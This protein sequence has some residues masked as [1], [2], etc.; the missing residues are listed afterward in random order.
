MA[1]DVGVLARRLL[2]GALRL[3]ESFLDLALEAL[4]AGKAYRE[5]R[6]PKHSGGVRILHE[7]CPT[8]MAV[9]EQIL[10]LLYRLYKFPKDSPLFGYVPGRSIVDNAMF[11]GQELLEDR[12][13]GE[14]KSYYKLRFIP[15]WVVRLDLKDA[16]PSVKT[17]LLRPMY[18]SLLA[19]QPRRWS[20]CKLTPELLD[21]VVSFLL[22]FT[23]YQGCIPQGAPSSGYLLNLSLKYAGVIDRIQEI[24]QRFK[25]PLRFSIYADDITI[26]S[27]KRRIS[28]RTIQQIMAA[29]EQGGWFRVNPKKTQRTR[30]KDRA[31]C[32]IGVVLTYRHQN[33]C[34]QWRQPILTLSQETLNHW[35]G[36]LHT[37]ACLLE[38]GQEPSRESNGF[39]LEQVRGYAQW[40]RQVYVANHWP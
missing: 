39:S 14:R 8:L 36:C 35:R 38:Q 7:P 13:G 23:T 1:E 6:I 40:I 29:I 33:S 31:H 28:D 11:H 25:Q 37:A 26:S 9:Q 21:K 12:C 5:I 34:P 19:Y 4:A 3:N 17:E 27:K 30:L 32:I 2:A 24:C 22:V 18:G 16:F 15:R 10:H 20:S